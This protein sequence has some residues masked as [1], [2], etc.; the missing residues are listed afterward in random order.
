MMAGSRLPIEILVEIAGEIADV[1]TLYDLS[2]VSRTW[3]QVVQPLL[4]CSIPF[5]DMPL[6]RPQLQ[7][8]LKTLERNQHL[9]SFVRDVKLTSYGR[10]RSLARSDFYAEIARLVHQ[11]SNLTSLEV[12]DS[13]IEDHELP[14]ILENCTSLVELSLAG[15]YNITSNGIIKALS[16]LKN[17]QRLK[18]SAVAT[19]LDDNCLCGI[20]KMCPLL[21]DLDLW[22]TSVARSR[23]S[24]IMKLAT[25]LRSLNLP[26]GRKITDL[27]MRDIMNEKPSYLTI[28]ACNRCQ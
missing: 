21:E 5:Q 1:N 22:N 14:G 7:L 18:L 16:L 25:R 28:T 13:S 8:L 12:T 4:Y 9:A 15:C 10:V 26:Q 27:E 6:I 20:V 2:V 17:V 11:S 23:V 24:Y 19:R 3:H